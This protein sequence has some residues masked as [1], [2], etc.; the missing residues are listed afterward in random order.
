MMNPDRNAIKRQYVTPGHPS[1]FS[2]IGRVAAHHGLKTRNAREL[3]SEISSYTLHREA[4]RPRYRNPY[5]VYLRREQC[6][7]DLIDV[8]QLS[9]FNDNHKYLVCAIDSFSRKLW[10]RPVKAK[11]ARLVLEA[12]RSIVD[13]MGDKPRSFFADKGTEMK[14]ATLINY[15]NSQDITLLHPN[16]EIKAGIVESTR[17]MLIYR[18]YI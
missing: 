3:L 13:A 2:G 6:Q 11:T 9:R 12:F 10:V 4:K 5:F 18:V 1:A 17:A 14:N 15:L 8:Q 7:A 16:S